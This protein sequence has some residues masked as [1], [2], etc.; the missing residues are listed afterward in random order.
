MS[1]H[2]PQVVIRTLPTWNDEP[3][4][5]EALVL[6]ELMLAYHRTVHVHSERQEHDRAMSDPRVLNEHYAARRR[7]V[8]RGENDCRFCH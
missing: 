6:K 4:I 3:S 1:R 2:L 8:E 5:K 7:S